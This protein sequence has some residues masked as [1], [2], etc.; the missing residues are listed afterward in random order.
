MYTSPRSW[1]TR[2]TSGPLHG[3]EE[4]LSISFEAMIHILALT[5]LGQ[6]AS[7]CVIGTLVSVQKDCEICVKFE[8][9]NA[10]KESE[11]VN[12]NGSD[13]ETALSRYL[14]SLKN[15]EQSICMLIGETRVVYR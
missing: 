4:L 1:L 9:R 7:T 8:D 5:N 12:V 3:D 6:N 13:M 2:G 10:E 11:K 14:I 15:M